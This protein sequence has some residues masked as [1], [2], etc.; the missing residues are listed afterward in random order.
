MGYLQIS[1]LPIE[2]NVLERL[3]THDQVE[4]L[5]RMAPFQNI[6]ADEATVR[7][8]LRCRIRRS[9][10]HP[11]C[12]AES[13]EN[14]GGPTGPAS[15][16]TNVGAVWQLALFH[17][18]EDERDS[19]QREP[20]GKLEL[21]PAFRIVLSV[22]LNSRPPCRWSLFEHPRPG[23]LLQLEI[24]I[25]AGLAAVRSGRESLTGPHS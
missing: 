20:I 11:G 24:F 1:T 10:V 23:I 22:S 16:V 8:P 17:E 2:L 15:K 14:P 5:G 6:R 3:L 9:K 13:S 19:C 18:P 4:T 21:L 12:R 7:I 25:N